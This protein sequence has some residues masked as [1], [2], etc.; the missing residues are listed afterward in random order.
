MSQSDDVEAMVYL[1]RHGE[2]ELNASGCLRGGVDVDLNAVGR[3][4]ADDLARLF[5]AVT[6]QR[7]I[8][9][10]L[11]RARQTAEPTARAMGLNVEVDDALNDRDFGAWAGERQHDVEA[12][13]GS[14]DAAPGVESW[15]AL[16]QRVHKAFLQIAA[17][18]DSKPI[19]IVGHDAVNR[20]LLH[21]L[22]PDLAHVPRDIPQ[23][24]GCW[25]KLV[26]RRGS[27]RAVIVNARPGDGQ[28]PC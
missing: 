21:A 11:R 25:N 2:T 6:L 22:A 27:W 9:S 16:G 13:F 12:Q 28:K 14:L 15:Q 10:P 24:T 18:L 3:R 8:S 23:T 26:C 20:A 17:T 7:V 1:L 5:Q 19:I 4:Q